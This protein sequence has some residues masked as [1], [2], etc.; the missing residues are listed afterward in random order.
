M[1]VMITQDFQKSLYFQTAEMGVTGLLKDFIIN[2]KWR[3]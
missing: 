1:Y 2:L 3:S